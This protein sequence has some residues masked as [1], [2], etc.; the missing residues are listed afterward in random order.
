[1]AAGPRYRFGSTRWVPPVTLYAG[2][3]SAH[4]GNG[5]D[6]ARRNSGAREAGPEK[7]RVPGASFLCRNFACILGLFW[8]QVMQ[9]PHRTKKWRRSASKREHSTER[10]YRCI[11]RISIIALNIWLEHT[12]WE[13]GDILSYLGRGGTFVRGFSS[14]AVTFWCCAWPDYCFSCRIFQPQFLH[15]HVCSFL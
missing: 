6:G 3:I 14:L 2:Y 4:L 13:S 1:M 8:S 9:K 7:R 11:R 5:R 12:A 15:V 10:R